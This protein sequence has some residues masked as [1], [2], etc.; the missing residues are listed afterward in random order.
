MSTASKV[1]IFSREAFFF[2]LS[3]FACGKHVD[4]NLGIGSDAFRGGSQV[5]PQ[6]GPYFRPFIWCT[7][8]RYINAWMCLLGQVY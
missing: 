5:E 2:F 4:V 6:M 1:S 7:Y 3:R 8:L